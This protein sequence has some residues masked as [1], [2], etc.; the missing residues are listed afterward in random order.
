MVWPIGRAMPNGSHGQGEHGGVSIRARPIGRAMRKANGDASGRKIV[1]IRARPIGH[2][3]THI[4][5]CSPVRA[6][7]SA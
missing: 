5:A 7:A 1:S 6:L 4:F 3:I 2:A